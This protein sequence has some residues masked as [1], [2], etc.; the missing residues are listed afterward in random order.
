MNSMVARDR[1]CMDTASQLEPTRGGV[2]SHEREHV[3]LLRL[4]SLAR[5]VNARGSP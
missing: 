3:H 5:A 1:G 4:V 2:V